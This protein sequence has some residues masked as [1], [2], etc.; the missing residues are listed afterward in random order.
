ML[1]VSG[2]TDYLIRDVECEY[3]NLMQDDEEDAMGAIVVALIGYRRE[4]GPN[5]GG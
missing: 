2:K 4:F 1:A 3:L 5:A